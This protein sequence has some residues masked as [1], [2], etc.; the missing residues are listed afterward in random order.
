MALVAKAA[1][2]PAMRRK[3]LSIAATLALLLA[4]SAPALNALEQPEGA[5]CFA[6]KP[7]VKAKCP[8]PSVRRPRPR[9]AA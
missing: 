4:F 5:S 6:P 8:R 9:S 2:L 7:L 3:L 1:M